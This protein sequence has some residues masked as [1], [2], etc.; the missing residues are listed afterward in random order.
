MPLSDF[1]TEHRVEVSASEVESAR[2]GLEVGRCTVPIGSSATPDEVARAIETHNADITILRYPAERVT[3][4]HLLTGQLGDHVLLHADTLVYWQLRVGEGQR[5]SPVTSISAS[6]PSDRAVVDELTAEIFADYSNHY[7]ANPLLSDEAA[8]AGYREWAMATPL[9]DVVVLYEGGSAIGMAT[10]VS[11]SDHIE[12]LLAGITP[13]QRGRGLYSHLL[14]E[15][16]SR[17][18]E[19]SLGRVVISTQVHNISAQRAW[20]R[21]GFLPFAAFNTVHVIR[22]EVWASHV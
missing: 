19:R 10:T 18:K 16:E 17:A 3:W 20:A 5:P 15:V 21:Y 1:T 2:F 14:G 12:I 13:G 22:K 9:H 4:D 6:E 7:S 11:T 8:E